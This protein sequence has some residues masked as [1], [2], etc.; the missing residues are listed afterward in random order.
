MVFEVRRLKLYISTAHVLS[1]TRP[2]AVVCWAASQAF[3][4]IITWGGWGRCTVLVEARS[5]DRLRQNSCLC[6]VLPYLLVSRPCDSEMPLLLALAQ[7][8]K[9]PQAIQ[10]DLGAFTCAP[11]LGEFFGGQ[12]EPAS[13][14]DRS[15]SGCDGGDGGDGEHMPNIASRLRSLYANRWVG[16]VF[17]IS[18]G[19]GRRSW[20]GILPR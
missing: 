7:F 6:I 13:I 18:G 10:V 15:N 11:G 19:L 20:R 1:A 8:H 4:I 16:G 12:G 3:C 2:P 9:R 14:L 17:K 5:R